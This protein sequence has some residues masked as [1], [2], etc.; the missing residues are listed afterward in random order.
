MLGISEG[1]ISSLREEVGEFRRNLDD[2]LRKEQ[3]HRKQIHVLEKELVELREESERLRR[4]NRE[5]NVGAE[6]IRELAEG[7][8]RLGSQ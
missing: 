6:R 3:S 5:L 7:M 2:A 1:K 4:N 8:I